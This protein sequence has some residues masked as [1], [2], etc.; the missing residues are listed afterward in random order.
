MFYNGHKYSSKVSTK[1]NQE[2]L[3]DNYDMYCVCFVFKQA[4]ANCFTVV[5][6]IQLYTSS[7]NLMGVSVTPSVSL[8]YIWEIRYKNFYCQKFF[9]RLYLDGS[10]VA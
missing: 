1:K 7:N 8:S 6:I 3:V 2:N 9:C 10:P 5:T 4:S